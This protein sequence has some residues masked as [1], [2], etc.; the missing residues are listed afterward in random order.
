M[1]DDV[2][3]PRSTPA[4][5]D[6]PI[7]PSCDAVRRDPGASYER[8]AAAPLVD[9]RDRAV[10]SA[11]IG[12]PAR[13]ETAVAH[14]CVFGLPTVARVAP[15]LDDGTPFPTVFWLTCPV[16]TSRVGTLEADHEM[17]GVNARLDDPED[18]L[19]T[20]HAAATD[21]YVRFRDEV[22]GALPGDPRAGGNERYVKCLHV[23]VAHHLATGDGPVGDWAV[24]RATP[25]PCSGP[26]VS[27]GQVAAR[28]TPDPGHAD[29]GA[30]R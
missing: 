11:Q 26:C 30:P 27:E 17:V 3:A 22:G 14:R 6:A 2:A 25:A 13:G 19:G 18:E 1:S 28:L 23:H 7:A 5:L 4:D 9:A 8:V 16:M 20:A 24:D 15:R 12:R 29:G 10:V 21:R